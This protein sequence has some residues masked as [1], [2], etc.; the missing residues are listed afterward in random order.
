MTFR[1]SNAI[2]NILC[3]NLIY[4]SHNILSRLEKSNCILTHKC[5]PTTWRFTLLFLVGESL[6]STRHRKLPASFSCKKKCEEKRIWVSVRL[7]WKS[8]KCQPTFTGFMTSSAGVLIVL[9]I[10]RFSNIS[11]SFQ[12]DGV[13]AWFPRVS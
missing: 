11:S 6:K 7:K 4:I 10:A 1:H 9:N 5:L 12:C 13:P 2:K 3:G 8:I